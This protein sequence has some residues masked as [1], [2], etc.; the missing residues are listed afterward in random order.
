VKTFNGGLELLV[1]PFLLPSLVGG[2]SWL[3]QHSWED[4]GD[5]NILLQILDKLLKPSSSSQETKTM[6]SAIL[7]IVADPLYQSL[8]TLS[9]RQPDKKQ[10][11]PLMNILKP[12]L[13]QRRTAEANKAEL[14]DWVSSKNDGLTGRVRT[15]IQE[16][17]VWVTDVGPSPPPRY[18]HRLFT[19]GYSILGANRMRDAIVSELK[20]QTTIGSGP[21]ALDIC[22]AIVCSPQS[23]FQDQNVLPLR[24]ALRLQTSELQALLRVSCP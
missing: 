16:L 4:H 17:V 19:Y 5:A 20:D 9:Q 7:E 12:H 6:H 21:Q 1:E 15:S 23:S 3:V 11:G 10:V 18:T 2:L 14:E 24:N 22:T 13:N 8:Q